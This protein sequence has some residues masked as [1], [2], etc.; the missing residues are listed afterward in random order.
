MCKAGS[1]WHM[2]PNTHGHAVLAPLLQL[3][4]INVEDQ[5]FRDMLFDYRITR[6]GVTCVA[7][8]ITIAS[9]P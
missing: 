8:S 9:H 5:D 7:K 6:G 2:P 4:V 3:L 1:C